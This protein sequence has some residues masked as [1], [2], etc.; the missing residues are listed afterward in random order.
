MAFEIKEGITA[1]ELATF[2]VMEIH[3][4]TKITKEFTIR[5]LFVGYEWDA[6]DSD[7]KKLAERLFFQKMHTPIQIIDAGFT[8]DKQRIYRIV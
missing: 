1:E 5:D 7:T 3:N 6:I 4:V 2:A 8:D